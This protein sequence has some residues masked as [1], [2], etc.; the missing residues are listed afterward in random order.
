LRLVLG[1]SDIVREPVS[2][3]RSELGVTEASLMAVGCRLERTADVEVARVT[4]A[5]EARVME[6]LEIGRVDGGL[7]KFETLIYTLL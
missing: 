7:M 4:P 5:V 1:V 3:I 6:M 2:P